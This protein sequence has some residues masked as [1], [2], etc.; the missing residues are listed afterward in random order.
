MV[1]LKAS[2]LRSDLIKLLAG[3]TA[4]SEA[5]WSTVIEAVDVHPMARDPRCNW[6]VR[7]LGSAEDLQALEHALALAK[8][9][10]PYV[11]KG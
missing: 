8:A 11:D 7:A 2:E 10:H 6:T 5:H 9:E 4:T 3:A 1:H